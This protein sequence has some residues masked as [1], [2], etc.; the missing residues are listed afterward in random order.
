MHTA[1]RRGCALTLIRGKSSGCAE[2]SR[3]LTAPGV[4]CEAAVRQNIQN[5]EKEDQ[6]LEQLEP[7]AFERRRFLTAL[8]GSRYRQPPAL[9]EVAEFRGPR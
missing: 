6:R 2:E 5:Q 1:S 7:G 3:S 8:S 4:V 9:S